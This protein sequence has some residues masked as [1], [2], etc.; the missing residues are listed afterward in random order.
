M[1]WIPKC[2]PRLK[3]SSRTLT[4]LP[5]DQDAQLSPYWLLGGL[6]LIG[7]FALEHRAGGEVAAHLAALHVEPIDDL[8]LGE[9]DDLPVRHC[10]AERGVLLLRPVYLLPRCANC[11]SQKYSL[12]SP[13][14]IAILTASLFAV[15]CGAR[16]EGQELGQGF[17][18]FAEG[19]SH[20]GIIHQDDLVALGLIH[21]DSAGVTVVEE[22]V[23]EDE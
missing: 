20:G 8:G 10:L 12:P 21:E 14:G 13:S 9:L 18:S 3:A 17:A 15:D 2:L 16:A 5:A 1:T 6:E 11:V 23:G 19:C 22:V 7:R 4:R